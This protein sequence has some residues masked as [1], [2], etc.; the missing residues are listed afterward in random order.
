MLKVTNLSVKYNPSDEYALKDVEYTVQSGER[1]AVIG[2]NGAGKSTLLLA[3][4][5]ILAHDSGEI[6]IGGVIMEKKTLREI[7]KKAGMIFQ[8]PDDQLFMPTV[9]ED[10]SFGPRNYDSPEH[11]IETKMDEVLSRL[12]ISHLKWRLSNKLSGGEKRLAAL[13]SVLIM[14]PALLLMDEPTSFLDPKA[15]RRLI[16]FL[17]TLPQTM[18]IAT[19]DLDL[20]LDL[21][22]RTILLKEGQIH[23]DAAARDVLR[24]ASLLDECSLELPLSFQKR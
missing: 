18:I 5:G 4:T 17:D 20:A 14:E 12:N 15:R 11:E 6:A 10:I 23:T 3:L 24:D 2:A 9:Y 16:R 7:R 8:N 19:H 1:I 22:Q 21:C 13:A